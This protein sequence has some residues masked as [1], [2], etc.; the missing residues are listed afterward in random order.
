MWQEWQMYAIR[1]LLIYSSLAARMV[2][3]PRD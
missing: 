3:N 1:L 2:S